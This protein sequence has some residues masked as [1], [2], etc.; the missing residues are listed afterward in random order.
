MSK[1]SIGSGPLM[2]KLVVAMPDPRGSPP[3]IL[4]FPLKLREPRE[5]TIMGGARDATNNNVT[6]SLVGG[7]GDVI[8]RGGREGC[9]EGVTRENT[10]HIDLIDLEAKKQGP[11]TRRVGSLKMQKPVPERKFKEL[12]KFGARGTLK[13]AMVRFE[14]A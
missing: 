5:E 4:P 9:E 10:T 2:S 7:R 11:Q 8:V 1:L 3:Q 12:Q 14:I 6:K 13:I